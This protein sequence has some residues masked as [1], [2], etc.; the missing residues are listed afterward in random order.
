MEDLKRK[1]VEYIYEQGEMC[2][3]L[4]SERE[5]AL[6]FNV[7]RSFVR[8][9]LLTLEGEGLLERL[10]RC[11][12]K[13]V[14]YQDDE[15]KNINHVRYAVEHEALQSAVQNAT[16]AELSSLEK[17]YLKMKAAAES[18]DL[19]EYAAMDKKFHTLIVHSSKSK[20]LIRVFS[21]ISVPVFNRYSR[22][23]SYLIF[24]SL[25][26][27]ENILRAMQNRNWSEAEIALHEHLGRDLPL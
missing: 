19:D 8:E 4:L 17:L 2:R 3:G 26:K 16:E 13:F 18:K 10:P 27:H 21:F 15:S 25:E 23:T 22:N 6:K 11:G 20:F 9:I 7:K 12:Y 24:D 5:L 14:H 1:I